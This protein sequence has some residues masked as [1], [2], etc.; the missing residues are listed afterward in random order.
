VTARAHALL[1]S[2]ASFDTLT[3][4]AQVRCRDCACHHRKLVDRRVGICHARR[5]ASCWSV[6]R[7]STMLRRRRRRVRSAWRACRSRY[8]HSSQQRRVRCVC[9]RVRTCARDLTCAQCVRLS[10]LSRVAAGG[11]SVWPRALPQRTSVPVVAISLTSSGAI[12]NNAIAATNT[13]SMSSPVTPSATAPT[14]RRSRFIDRVSV[15]TTAVASASGASLN[16]AGA[17]NATPVRMTSL[18]NTRASSDGVTA[19]EIE[20]TPIVNTITVTTTAPVAL[21]R[22]LEWI[23][24]RESGALADVGKGVFGA[25]FV[26]TA[27]VRL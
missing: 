5:R 1:L 27:C 21:S 26:L 25:V 17:L 9:C 15:D 20:A 4:A 16:D 3:I 11:G 13:N 10:G 14:L 2:L 19:D 7:H 23:E 18:R 6:W 12:S 8:V 24:A 22:L